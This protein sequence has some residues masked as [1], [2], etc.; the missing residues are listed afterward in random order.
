ML[1]DEGSVFIFS[2]DSYNTRGVE[3]IYV[4]LK[5]EDKWTEPINL[6]SAVNSSFQELA[7]SMSADGKT[8]FFASNGRNGFGGFDI[9]Q[10]T[11]LDE[12]WTLGRLRQNMQPPLNTEARELFYRPG[13]KL[14]LFTTT[15][16]SDGY[17]DIRA[18]IDS[19]QQNKTDTLIKILEVNRDLNAAR[20]KW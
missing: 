16:N 14:N 2:A 15:R 13:K 4:S 10:S 3:D 5:K 6:G 8:I 18:L 11:R 19:A 7:P 9:Y 12:S 20:S 1:N 17:G